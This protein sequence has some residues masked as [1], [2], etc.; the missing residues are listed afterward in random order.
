[1]IDHSREEFGFHS[2]RQSEPLFF[3]MQSFNMPKSCKELNLSVITVKRACELNKL[4][5]SRLPII[6]WSNVVRNTHYVNYVMIKDGIFFAVAIWSSPVAGN[7]MTAGDKCLEL[8]R[9]AI[10]PDAPK[11][12]AT[13][14]ISLMVK[15]IKKRFPD[16]M[17]LV[18]YQDTEVHTG[19]IYKASNW[20]AEKEVQGISW[21]TNTRKR[22]KEQTIAKKIRWS[23][24]I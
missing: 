23:L 20:Y 8:R 24:T 5:H 15:D 13:R 18:S 2:M 19:T 1:M 17:K 14:M 3:D 4:W 6:D 9:L 22:N 7:R 10:S 16:I 11:Y 12:T 21:T